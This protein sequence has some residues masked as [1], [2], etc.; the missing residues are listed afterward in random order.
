LTGE[1]YRLQGYFKHSDGCSRFFCW[2]FHA[3]W[4]TKELVKLYKDFRSYH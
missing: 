3:W 1:V 2:N 4:L